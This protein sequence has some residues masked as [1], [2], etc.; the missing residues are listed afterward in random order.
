LVLRN[1][2]ANEVSDDEVVVVP[3]L[4]VKRV[5]LE[6]LLDLGLT[7][8]SNVDDKFREVHGIATRLAA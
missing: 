3:P 7:P 4:K 1:E 5:S 6:N 8:R 2:S